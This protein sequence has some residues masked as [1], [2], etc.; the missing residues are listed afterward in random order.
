MELFIGSWTKT[1]LSVNLYI[2]IM[3]IEGAEMSE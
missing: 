2:R 3:Q 1:V